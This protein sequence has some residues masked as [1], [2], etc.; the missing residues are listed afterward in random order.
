[1]HR[2]NGELREAL[3]TI[4][5]LDIIHIDDCT[6][7]VQYKMYKG[8][9]TSKCLFENDDITIARTKFSA[10]AILPSHAHENIVEH[11][12]VESGHVELLL[13]ETGAK[14]D[15]LE[16]Q[17]CTIDPDVLH[18]A[19]IPEETTIIVITMPPSR[20]FPHPVSKE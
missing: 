2:S 4:P 19:K 13:C 17:C 5:K 12:L 16:R 14:I 15:V 8:T 20:E 10:G 18:S 3:K 6:G 9:A 1:M 11:L 7:T